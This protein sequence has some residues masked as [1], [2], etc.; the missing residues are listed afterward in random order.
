[1]E[2]HGVPCRLTVFPGESHGFRRADTI[3][4]CLTLELG[5]YRDLF[6]P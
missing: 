5:F 4:A 2:D 6:G 1:L 3:E